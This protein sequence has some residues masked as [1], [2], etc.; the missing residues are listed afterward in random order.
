MVVLQSFSRIH[1]DTPGYGFI[2]TLIIIIVLSALAIR[3]FSLLKEGFNIIKES[4]YK[5][6]T[7]KYSPAT[8]ENAAVYLV[9]FPYYQKLS[10]R[11]KAE[12][13][14]RTLNFLNTKNIEGEND[15]Q[16][17]LAARIHVAAAATQL[18]F[19]LPDFSFSHFD[20]V[21][22]YPTIFKLSE[23]APLMKGA[24]T[25]D[26]IVRISVR[27]FDEGYK[28]STDKLN[29]GLHELG[30]ALFM[31]FLKGVSEEQGEEEERNFAVTNLVHPYLAESDRILHAG[32]EH[33]DFLRQYA[34][35]NRHE[36]FAVSIEHFFEAPSEFKEK[37]PV[38]YKVMTHLLNQDPNNSSRDYAL[39]GD[40][41]R[42]N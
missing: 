7:V 28:N 36:F 39:T 6:G 41:V 35:T 42:V 33:A 3:F 40:F 16:P 38:L 37:L 8:T 24:T 34:F 4:A 23:R 31:E 5:S 20:N 30:H 12:F 18:T 25:P 29:V 26:G 14:R 1:T 9:S 10:Q 13:I 32:K 11:G 19:G 21:V 17:D 22:L 27:D 15:Y 2:T